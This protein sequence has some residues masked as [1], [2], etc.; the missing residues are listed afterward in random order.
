MDPKHNELQTRHTRCIFPEDVEQ[1]L[2]RFSGRDTRSEAFVRSFCR[3][4]HLVSGSQP[5]VGWWPEPGPSYG[6]PRLICRR[7]F[8]P[9]SCAQPRAIVLHRIPLHSVARSCTRSLAAVLDPL[10]LC[11]TRCSGARPL[12][13][14][15]DHCPL[16]RLTDA[17]LIPESSCQIDSWEKAGFTTPD[18]TMQA[19]SKE[20]TTWRA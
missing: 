9:C 5:S 8:G 10:Q 16:R 1:S 19:L 2:C 18:F 11:S 6:R 20:E 13:A 3:S 17:E 15:L 4:K 14:V 7:P 12:A